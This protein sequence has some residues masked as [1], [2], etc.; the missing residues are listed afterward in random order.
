MNGIEQ[1]LTRP[2]IQTFT[3]KICQTAVHGREISCWWVDRRN[4]GANAPMAKIALSMG[5]LTAFDTRTRA[6]W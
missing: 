6:H 2:L 5:T 1:T 4:R 3:Q